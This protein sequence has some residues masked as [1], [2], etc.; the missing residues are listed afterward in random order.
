MKSVDLQ[1]S[2]SVLSL[3]LLPFPNNPE[4]TLPI[5]EAPF[6]LSFSKYVLTT[7]YVPSSVADT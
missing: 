5:H 7:F 3:V 6:I 4:G 2:L 1:Q